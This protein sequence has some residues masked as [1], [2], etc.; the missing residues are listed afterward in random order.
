MV[1]DVQV[2]VVGKAKGIEMGGILQFGLDKVRMRGK[3]L[4]F[5]DSLKLDISDLGMEEGLSVKDIDIPAEL[6]VLDDE[7][8]TVV[9]IVDSSKIKAAAE[10]EEAEEAAGE[11]A[12]EAAEAGEAES[13]GGEEAAE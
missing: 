12:A 11:E 9:H 13:S 2:E 10:A 5:P 7:N 1:L 3:I 8:S 6:E 4:D